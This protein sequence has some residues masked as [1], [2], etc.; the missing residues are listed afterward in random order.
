MTNI[1]HHVPLDQLRL[2]P[3]SND[4]A[5]ITVWLNTFTS[6]NTQAVYAKTAADFLAFVAKPLNQVTVSDLQSWLASRPD[7]APASQNTRLTALRS[8]YRLGTKIGYLTRN[9]TAVLRN[10]PVVQR[11]AERILSEQEVKTLLS[12]PMLAR[13]RALLYL[14]YAAGLRASEVVSLQWRDVRYRPDLDQIQVTV[15]GKGGKTRAVLVPAILPF[16]M[17]GSNDIQEHYLFHRPHHPDRPLTRGQVHH[18][19]KTVASQQPGINPAVSAHW[20]RHAH[21]THALERGA[22]LPLVQATLGHASIKTTSVYLHVRP[23]LSSGQYLS[24][25]AAPPRSDSKPRS[26]SEPQ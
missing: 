25:L 17:P 21:A 7:L 16:L 15:F 11:R 13:N 2:L 26:D 22:P 12:A 8:L 19:I 10:R 23:G 5:L 24:P 3:S 18:I 9:P 1:E 6:P 4:Q 14:L 20:L